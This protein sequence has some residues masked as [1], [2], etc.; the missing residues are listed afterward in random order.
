MHINIHFM[1][2]VHAMKVNLGSIDRL[3][4]VLLAIVIGIAIFNGSL[5]G[6]WAWVLGAFGVV[7][8]LTSTVSRC[9]IYFMLGMSTAKK[10]R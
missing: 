3:V 2:G 7:L 10:A 8:L 1:E 4:R 5:T 9:P 6:V